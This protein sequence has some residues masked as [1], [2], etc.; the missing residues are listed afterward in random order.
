MCACDYHHLFHAHM[1]TSFVCSFL[2]DT[3]VRAECQG[4]DTQL[5]RTH[6]YIWSV[7]M[8]V[9]YFQSF[10]PF[11]KRSVRNHFAL[12]WSCVTGIKIR[13]YSSV[14]NVRTTSI[15]YPSGSKMNA[16]K[17]SFPSDRRFLNGTPSLSKRAHAAWTSG[18][19]I[20]MWPNPRGSELPEWYC[21]SGLFS[22][23]WLWVSSRMP[24][25][26]IRER[27]AIMVRCAQST[28]REVGDRGGIT[29]LR[30]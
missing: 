20:A 23:P 10:K 29:H 15:Q 18:T 25:R 5:H 3:L 1:R 4:N 8:K 22:V 14:S 7:N 24:D 2:L 19:V 28:R 6:N 13:A 16:R 27:D 11:W 26:T 30:G 12:C 21:T 9:C 17:F